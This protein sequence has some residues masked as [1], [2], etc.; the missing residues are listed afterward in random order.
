M[1]KIGAMP[2]PCLHCGAC[3]ASFRV[4]FHWSE[5]EDA[6]GGQ[7]PA[8]LTAPLRRHERMMRGSD[9]VPP[10]C[11]ALVGTVGEATRCAIHPQRPSPCRAV[12]PS[13][14][15][16]AADAHCDRARSLHGLPL[17]RPEDWPPRQA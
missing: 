17:L 13:W 3:C 1:P 15:N 11:V 10:R 14:E 5:G 7:V 16:G 12:M 6:P 9:D 8:A 4:A 2:H